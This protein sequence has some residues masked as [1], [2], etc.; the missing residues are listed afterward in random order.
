MCNELVEMLC[1]EMTN[2]LGKSNVSR[3]NPERKRKEPKGTEKNSEKAESLQRK[4]SLHKVM[5]N[6]CV[7]NVKFGI[8]VEALV[9]H[10]IANILI[11]LM[12]VQ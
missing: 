10:N 3:Y 2:H 7:L 4:S 11:V 12:R 1:T 6:G 8:S 5:E 9:K